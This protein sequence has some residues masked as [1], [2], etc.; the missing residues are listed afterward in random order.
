[1]KVI[2]LFFEHAS[3]K[4]SADKCFHFYLRIELYLTSDY[5]NIQIIYLEF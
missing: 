4:F 3:F 1:M 2:F 5:N